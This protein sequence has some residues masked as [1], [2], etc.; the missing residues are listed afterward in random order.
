MTYIYIFYYILAFFLNSPDTNCG[1]IT[2]TLQCF[3]TSLSTQCSNPNSVPIHRSQPSRFH[4]ALQ[5]H[6]RSSL[7][8]LEVTT[9]GFKAICFTE[10]NKTQQYSCNS[11]HSRCR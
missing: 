10:S 11:L 6:L 5:N 1:Q 3:E 4:F 7:N 8:Y 2:K 9:S